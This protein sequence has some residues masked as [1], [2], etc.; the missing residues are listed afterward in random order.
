VCRNLLAE[1]ALNLRDQSIA[2][3]IDGILRIE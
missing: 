3:L 1:L 2:L